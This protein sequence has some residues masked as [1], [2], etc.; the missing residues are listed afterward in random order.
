M[1]FR[2]CN[3]DKPLAPYEIEVHELAVV[4]TS[5]HK[6]YD[7]CIV[8]RENDDKLRVLGTN[9]TRGIFVT[10]WTLRRLVVGDKFIYQN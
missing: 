5:E 9:V 8:I 3:I 4:L 1:P 10:P 2:L 7:G 6:T